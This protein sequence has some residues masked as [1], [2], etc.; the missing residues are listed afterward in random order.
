[1]GRELVL[2]DEVRLDQLDSQTRLADA[3][4][5]DDDKLVFPQ[6]LCGGSATRLGAREVPRRRTLDAMM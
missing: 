1:M 6:E 5:A 3:T 4:T 2:V